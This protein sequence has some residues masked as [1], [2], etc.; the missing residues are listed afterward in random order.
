MSD[1]DCGVVQFP[2]FLTARPSPEA[3]IERSEELMR[4]M[5]VCQREL[6]EATQAAY[7]ELRSMCQGIAD[8]AAEAFK[9]HDQALAS[10]QERVAALERPSKP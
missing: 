9:A 8:A 3:T 7:A 2:S 6:L 4:Q 10:L 1:D 5:E